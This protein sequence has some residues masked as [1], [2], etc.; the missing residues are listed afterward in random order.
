MAEARDGILR[1]LYGRERVLQNP[2]Y[3]AAD[4]NERLIISDPALPAVHVLDTKNRRSFRIAGGVGRRLRLPS[5]V[6]VDGENNIYVADSER[7]MVFVY[8]PEGQFLR[9]IGDLGGGEGLFYHPTSIAID[10]KAGH[11]YVLDSPRLIMLDLQGKILKRIGKLRGD[12]RE[13]SDPKDI[14]LSNDE[15]LVVDTD[16]TRVQIMDRECNLLR[17]L[18]LSY[19]P[20]SHDIGVGVDHDGNIYV[21]FSD[22]SVIRVYDQEGALLGSFGGSGMRIGEFNHPTRLWIDPANR[23]YVADTGNVRVQV[24]QLYTPNNV[25]TGAMGSKNAGLQ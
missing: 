14:V 23:V 15:L 10:S 4:S 9:P 2:H 19:V 16:G 18:R 25:K 5:G 17:K 12:T 1:F 7:G 3:L 24:F 21:S 8:R 13:F 6:A 11:L 20:M 22:A